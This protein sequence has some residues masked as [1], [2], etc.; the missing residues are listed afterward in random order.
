M[1]TQ[2]LVTAALIIA[3]MAKKPVVA[4]EF[5]DGSGTKFN[6]KLSGSNKWSFIDLEDQLINLEPS[7]KVEAV[8]AK[9]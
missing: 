7:P 9:F 2:T 3:Q 4:I 1:N 8:T 5:E 6:F